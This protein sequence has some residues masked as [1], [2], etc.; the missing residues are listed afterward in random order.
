MSKPLTV[1]EF[2][3]TCQRIDDIRQTEY[4][5]AHGL[6][7]THDQQ[8]IPGFVYCGGW[9]GI[10]IL[11]NGQYVV[12]I[13]NQEYVFDNLILAEDELYQFGLSEGYCVAESRE[14]WNI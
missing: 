5:S 9:L 12:A 1:V 6:D 10:T 13:G 3:Q 8:P 2:R 14:G 7:E 11:D 4:G